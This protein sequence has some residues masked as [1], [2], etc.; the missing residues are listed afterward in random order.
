MFKIG[1]FSK[2]ARISIRMLRYYDENGL[3]KPVSIDKFTG[4]RYYSAAQISDANKITLYRDMGFNVIEIAELLKIKDSNVIENILF[5]KQKEIEQ[6][7][8]VEK[9]KINLINYQ[10]NNL[11]KRSAVTYEVSI[12]SVPKT[13]V[14]SYR[15]IIPA[16][17]YEGELW[18]K[19]LTYVDVNNIKQENDYGTTIFH[20]SEHREKG[21]DVE[22]CINVKNLR[23]SENGFTYR[24]VEG[25]D[26]VASILIV[27]PYDK[28]TSAI[29][30][31]SSWIEEK[32]YSMYGKHR[33]ITIKH[34]ENE[35][36]PNKY[37]TEIQIPVM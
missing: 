1:E 32:G 9:E 23:E 10:I 18:Q 2:L 8:N 16:Y 35:S 20:D 30:Y 21:C 6:L 29:E 17:N 4:Y 28:I 26:K 12:K 27:G 36:D 31:L 34:P 7:I 3:L 15:E 24:E 11:G 5:S 22:V 25:V 33:Q 14:V 19:L 37:V 13:K